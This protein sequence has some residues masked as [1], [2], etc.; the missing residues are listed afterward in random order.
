LLSRNT[1]EIKKVIKKD[2]EKT[3]NTIIKGLEI[4]KL[5]IFC[6]FELIIFDLR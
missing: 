4:G 6:T 3:V 2:D 5:R 1:I